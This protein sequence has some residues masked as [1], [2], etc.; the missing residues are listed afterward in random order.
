MTLKEYFNQ[1]QYYSESGARFMPIESMPYSHAYYAF[2][3]LLT[4]HKGQ[5]ATTALF[6]QFIEY[7]EPK[8]GEIINALNNHGKVAIMPNLWCTKNT[9]RS[10][11]YRAARELG[12]KVTTHWNGKWMEGE[13]VVPQTTVRIKGQPVA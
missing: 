11:I 12:V 5:F 1:A 2:R 3:K 13:V 8:P 4:E 10:R 9:A 6:F 7:L